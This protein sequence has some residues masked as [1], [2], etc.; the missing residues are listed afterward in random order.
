L[1]AAIEEAEKGAPKG[2]SDR[3]GAR[4]RGR[5]IGREHNRRVQQER[6]PTRRWTLERAAASRAPLSL[7]RDVLTLSPCAMCSGAILLYGIPHVIAGENRT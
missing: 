1:A 3:R 2:N 6:R 5:I 4:S 7:R